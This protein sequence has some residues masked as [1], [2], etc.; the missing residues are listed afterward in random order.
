MTFL[1]DMQNTNVTMQATLKFKR[2]WVGS[3]STIE[4]TQSKSV[5]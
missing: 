4:V 1:H 2:F 5:L 3:P